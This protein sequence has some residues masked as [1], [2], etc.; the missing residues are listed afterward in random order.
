MQRA[1]LLA[2]FPWLL[3][4]CSLPGAGPGDPSSG[5]DAAVDSSIATMGLP[6]DGGAGDD[7]RTG[8]APFVT[9]DSGGPLALKSVWTLPKVSISGI[10]IDGRGDVYL[11][12]IFN[13]VATFGSTT[14]A[15]PTAAGTENMFL[16]KYDPGGAVVFAKS[17]GTS[18]GIYIPPAIA[19]DPAGDVFLGGGFANT[20][21]FGGASTPLAS[22]SPLDGFAV[23]LSHEGATLWAERFGYGSGGAFVLSIAVAPDGNPILAGAAAGTVVLGAKTWP[24]ADSA[25]QPFIAKLDTTDG[26]VIWSNATG[27][28]VL[29]G[30]NV[31]VSTDATGRVFVAARVDSGGGAWGSQPVAG[32]GTFGTLRAGFDPGGSILWGQFDYGGY[33]VS[34]SVDQGGRF[35]VL[36][37]SYDTEGVGGSST[38][39]G[40]ASSGLASLSLLFSP[41]DGT[42][43]SAIHIEETEPWGAAVDGH[44]NSLLTGIYWPSNTS[45][46]PV[47][48][49]ALASDSEFNQPLFLAALDGTSRPVSLATMGSTS[50]AQPLGIAVDRRSGNV[51]VH[52]NSPTAFTSSIGPLQPGVFVAVFG[53]DP[54]DDGAGPK[55]PSTGNPSNHGDLLAD[56]GSPY[57]ASDGQAPAA[58]PASP[59]G[60]LNGAACPVAMGCSYGA[61]CCSCAPT[62]C[63][64][65]PTLWTCDNLQNVAQCPSSPPPPGTACPSTSLQCNYCLSG[66]RFYA[67]CM[68]GGWDTG[69]AQI[70][71]E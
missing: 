51:F 9:C 36:E 1:A 71:C 25:E 15:A 54:C 33:P 52:G 17:Y 3:W 11:T 62:A 31:F 6:G 48:S 46:R 20:L 4:G 10:A 12:G 37:S 34:A 45:S 38:S 70:V 44:G 28:N 19:V 47:G 40:D 67:D 66:G 65:E 61:T 2:V 49:L 24:A 50:D 68:A 69:Y 56:G 7:G 23:K 5:A 39:F 41:I 64:G 53:P 58:C 32:A 22:V 13:G 21:D 8:T 16:V 63:D 30:E 27:G 35:M 26:A 55:G 43:L 14:L 60:A 59:A 18:T 57:A 42:L 29:S